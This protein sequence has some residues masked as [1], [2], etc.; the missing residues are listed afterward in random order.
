MCKSTVKVFA[1][2]SPNWDDS[3]GL[4]A[5]KQGRVPPWQVLMVRCATVEVRFGFPC[6]ISLE[7]KLW[8]AVMFLIGSM[9]SRVVRAG[10]YQSEI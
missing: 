2:C 10:V 6:A 7:G 1:S 3:I 5:R 9:G 8:P 4:A